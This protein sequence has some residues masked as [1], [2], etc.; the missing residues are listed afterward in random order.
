MEKW[1]SEWTFHVHLVHVHLAVESRLDLTTRPFSANHQARNAKYLAYLAVRSIPQHV[2]QLFRKLQVVWIEIERQQLFTIQKIQRFCLRI[3]F[4]TVECLHTL[5]QP[6]NEICNALLIS[7]EEPIVDFRM[8]ATT[9][10]T[11]PGVAT[12][13]DTRK[14]LGLRRCSFRI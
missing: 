13:C 9:C 3:D 10:P 2:A 14:S 8:Q 6:S 4:E 7:R 5:V 11:T 1:T 12:D